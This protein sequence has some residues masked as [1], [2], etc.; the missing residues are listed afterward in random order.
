MPSRAGNMIKFGAAAMQEAAVASDANDYALHTQE[1]G[2]MFRVDP[3]ESAVVKR[4]ATVSRPKLDIMREV[5]K[6]VRKGYVR[7]ISSSKTIM[8][9]GEIPSNPG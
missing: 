2:M 9:E 3:R 5:E 4:G 8:A 1:Q 7:S 6:V